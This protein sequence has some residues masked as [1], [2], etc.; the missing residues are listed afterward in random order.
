MDAA[1]TASAAR[2]IALMPPPALAGVVRYFHV[3]CDSGG[4]AIVPATPYPMLTLFAAGGSLVP[5]VDGRLALLCEPML[6]GPVTAALPAVWQQGTCFISA[7]LEP[8]GFARLFGFSAAELRD[9]PVALADVDPAL[10][11][12][13]PAQDVLDT[14]DDP[15]RWADA[16]QRWLVSLLQRRERAAAPFVLPAALLALPTGE[17]ARHCGIGERQLERRFQHS[18]GQSLRA[19]RRMLRYTHALALLMRLPPRHGLLTRVAM[20]AGY[21]D[22]AHMVRDFIA[23]TG[24]PP[25]AWYAEPDDPLHRTYRYDAAQ[26]WIVTR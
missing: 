17:I 5:S 3:E 19:M 24:R 2:R 26:R 18:Y 13:A 10:P 11:S 1:T 20:D 14:T 8:A 22:Q 25:G 16:L 15:F 23:Y 9:T 4:P 21:H 7:L 12:I 6:C